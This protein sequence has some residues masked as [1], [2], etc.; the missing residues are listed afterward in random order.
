MSFEVWSNTLGTLLVMGSRE[1]QRSNDDGI[2]PTSILRDGRLAETDPLNP[3][4]DLLYKRLRAIAAGQME[5]QAD[6]HS[7][8]P[9]A[10]ANQAV[11]KMLLS[12]RRDW[13]DSNHVLATAAT[14]MRQILCDHARGKNRQKRRNKDG[15]RI[16]LDDAV[17]QLE[18]DASPLTELDEALKRLEAMSPD[19]ARIVELRFFMGLTVAQAAAELG[20]PK[21]TIERQWRHA[22]LWLSQEVNNDK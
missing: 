1:Q 5:H 9:T 4:L 14:M 15:I 10:L 16:T 8:Q 6:H 11:V 21:R 19:A 18:S 2:S 13:V 20:V 3:V 7:L 17:M 12:P 22:K